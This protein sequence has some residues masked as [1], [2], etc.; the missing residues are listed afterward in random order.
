MSHESRVG[1]DSERWGR[2]LEPFRVHPERAGV[3][4]DFDGT[5]SD[6]VFIPSDA[7]PVEGARAA[8]DALAD[9]LALLA[10]VS[11]RSAR[12]LVDWLGDEVE[13]WGTH[14][15]E[16]AHS[17][18]LEVAEVVRPYLS[19]MEQVKTK[20]AAE[21]AHLGIPGVIIEDKGS[22]IGLH[23]RAAEDRPRAQEALAGLAQRLATEYGLRQAG[24]RLAYELRP[25]VELSKAD[26]VLRRARECEL[27]A[28]M[29]IGD[30]RV[31]LPGFDAL[32]ELEREGIHAVRVAVDSAEAPAE[33][34]ERADLVL[35]GPLA[36]V[37]FLE[38]IAA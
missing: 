20:A 24:G 15:A 12:Q 37:G 3:F 1:Y 23:F 5:L 35:P 18:V 2:A 13:I 22:M 28:C 34:L 30:D 8:L 10:I 25:P 11:G 6:I 31:D 29:F 38:Q 7:R 19:M 27:A 26:V 9:K 21:V 16:R 33:L 14:G 4:V 32:D 17:G 36:V